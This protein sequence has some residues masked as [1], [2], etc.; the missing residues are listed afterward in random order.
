MRIATFNVE[1]L[2]QR[3][4]AMNLDTWDEGSLVLADFQ[5]LNELIQKP[6]YSD[7]VKKELLAI[8]QQP[9]NKG[10][11]TNGKSG[12]IQLHETRGRLLRRPRG[13]RV[14]VAVAGRA[15]WIGWFELL[16]E[17][18]RQ[19]ATENTARVIGLLEA[20]A[21]AVIEAEDRTG[22]KRF[23][24][25][26]LP[27]VGAAPFGHIM[28]I[29][30]NDERGIDVG[31]ATR[32]DFPIVRMCSHV[33][34]RDAKGVVF[35]RDCAEYEIRTPRGASLLLL[36]NHFK[37]KGYGSAAR[38][39]A[40]RRRQAQRVREIYQERLAAGCQYVAVVGDLNET[41][42]QSPLDP[43]IRQ[44]PRLTDVMEHPKFVSDGR[45][46]TW[47][48]GAKS[49]KLDYILMSPALCARVTAGGVE[50]RGVWGGKNGTLFPHL[51]AIEKSVDAASDHAAL[52]ADVDI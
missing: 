23:N 1:N 22:L 20:D 32:Q 7:A 19:T 21:L 13:G 37:S 45:P 48:A 14:E 33:D 42:G 28:L 10:L 49:N 11:I 27:A 50:R 3:P 12:F 47:G 31:I 16:K 2:F 8:L 6:A 35:S 26:V 41:P 29:D 36:V 17:P 46:G 25:G 39:A 43:L 40:K 5:R 30:G 38:S 15:E 24:E 4:K 51:P 34:D 44:E 52:W 18:V 9:R